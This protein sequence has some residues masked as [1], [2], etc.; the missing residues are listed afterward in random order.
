MGRKV[1]SRI[2]LRA[3]NDAA[4]A[5]EA[6]KEQD[7]TVTPKKKKKAAKRKSR[8]KTQVD[9]PKRLYWGVFNQSLKLVARFDFN[10]K[11]HAMKK[12]EELNKA[13]KSPHFVQK[14]KEE[15]IEE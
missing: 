10:Q 9:I 13:G 12:A 2:A 4:E 6:A 14:I 3:E 7:T 8:S 5:A 15:I 1:I 11:K